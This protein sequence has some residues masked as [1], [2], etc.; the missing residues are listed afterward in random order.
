MFRCPICPNE[1][2]R[3]ITA[4]VDHLEDKEHPFLQCMQCSARYATEFGWN[5]HREETGHTRRSGDAVRIADHVVQDET[6]E[7]A[8]SV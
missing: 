8:A 1:L 7:A 2:I 6:R 5:F 4:F 3:G